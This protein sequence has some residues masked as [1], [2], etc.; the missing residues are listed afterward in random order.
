MKVNVVMLA[1]NR[2]KLT[3]QAVDSLYNYTSFDLFN[4]TL[5]DDNSLRDVQNHVIHA[6]VAGAANLAALRLGNSKSI[7]GMARNLGVYWAEKF[8]GRGD[9]LYL[10]DNDICFLPEWIETLT[11]IA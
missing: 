11:D 8:W 2:P 9:W 1:K 10:S 6:A 7:T 5:I 3:R 4:L